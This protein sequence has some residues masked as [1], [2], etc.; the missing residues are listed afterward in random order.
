[1]AIVLKTPLCKLYYN[2]LLKGNGIRIKALSTFIEG[3]EAP[4]LV[5]HE[6]A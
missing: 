1:M 4:D 6:K 3:I 2:Q 5:R